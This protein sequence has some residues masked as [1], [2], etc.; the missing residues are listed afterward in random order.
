M[1]RG[2]RGAGSAGEDGGHSSRWAS[3]KGR[4]TN[5]QSA[6]DDSGVEQ[7]L[8]RDRRSRLAARALRSSGN[9]HGT[10]AIA[11]EKI[12]SWMTRPE[13]PEELRVVR[14]TERDGEVDAPA[15][16]GAL[17]K[18]LAERDERRRREVRMCVKE[19]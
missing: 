3:V 12:A 16:P 6:D 14:I 11:K 13:Q 1:K 5:L 2:R 10:V 18:F 17:V 8:L 15:I 19:I 4:R 9:L 7:V